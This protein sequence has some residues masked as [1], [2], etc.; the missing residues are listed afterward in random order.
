MS[1]TSRKEKF[2]D[3]LDEMFG[4]NESSKKIRAAVRRTEKRKRTQF[5]KAK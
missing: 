4:P 2:A 5:R 1:K 3:L